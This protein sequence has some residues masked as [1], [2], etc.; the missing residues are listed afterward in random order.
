MMAG[1]AKLLLAQLGA[2]DIE[3]R[4]TLPGKPHAAM[5]LHRTVTVMEQ[6][7]RCLGLGHA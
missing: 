5:E 1:I 6:G 7:L 2:A 3:L 4:F